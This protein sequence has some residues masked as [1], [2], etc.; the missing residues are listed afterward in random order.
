MAKAVVDSFEVIEINEQHRKTLLAAMRS[1]QRTI[2]LIAK[3][4]SIGKP[5][6]RIVMRLI[7]KLLVFG[8][9]GKGDSNSIAQVARPRPFVGS[10]RRVAP[11]AQNHHAHHVLLRADRGSKVGCRSEP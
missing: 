2:K 10:Q 4:E 5:G 6:E 9:G 7:V 11:E 3:V 1:S 8:G